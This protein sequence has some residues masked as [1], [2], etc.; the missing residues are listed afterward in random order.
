MNE[1]YIKYVKNKPKLYYLAGLL[2]RWKTYVSIQ[3]R[4][5][6]ARKNGANMGEGV[7]IT[8]KV[9]ATANYNLSI[10]DHS[11]VNNTYLD[12]RN[13]IK[14]GNHV[15]IGGGNSIITTSHDV[16]SPTF[17]RKD[18]GIEIEDYVWITTNAI[19][20]PTCRKIGY[21]AVIGCG[22]VVVGDVEPMAIM[23]GNPAKKI[24]ERQQVHLEH[25]PEINL[26][27]DYLL[28]KQARKA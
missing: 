9:A 11:T 6:K 2:V 27:G 10:G 8:K 15:I 16:N 4:I 28:Y 21:G 20:L 23:S 14:I 26:G 7:V 24:K 18:Y 5:K 3:R 22:S 25:N 12:L 19:I 1:D 17:A 13:P